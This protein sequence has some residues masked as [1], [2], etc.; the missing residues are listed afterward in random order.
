MDQ[1]EIHQLPRMNLFQNSFF[2]D[3]GLLKRGS[4]RTPAPLRRNGHYRAITFCR[5]ANESRKLPLPPP[6][7]IQQVSYFRIYMSRSRQKRSNS[8][9]KR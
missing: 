6:V 8:W 2:E 5:H 4:T 1:D 9:C 3:L 7:L